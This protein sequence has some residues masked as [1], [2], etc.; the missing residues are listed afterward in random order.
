MKVSTGVSSTRHLSTETLIGHL[1][2]AIPHVVIMH[3]NMRLYGKWMYER[4]DIAYLFKLIEH[5][6][7]KLDEAGGI[8]QPKTFTLE[9]WEEAF[10]V[11]AKETGFGK[12]AVILP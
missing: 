2:V 3:R 10:D 8:E 9:Q 12:S 11:A 6:L 7:L 1:D 4:S 5:G